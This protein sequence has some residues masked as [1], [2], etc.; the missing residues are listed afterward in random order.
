V[1][2]IKESKEKRIE[3][4]AIAN[5]ILFSLNSIQTKHPNS[6]GELNFGIKNL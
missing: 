6:N 3:V 1:F 5:S 2:V 4:F